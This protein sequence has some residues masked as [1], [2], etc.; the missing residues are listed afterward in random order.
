VID[1]F[2][3]YLGSSIPKTNI[4]F[5]GGVTILHGRLRIGGQ[6]DYRG[7]YLVY[8]NTEKFRCTGAGFN[9]AGINN[10]GD[11]LA[12]Q[13]RAV[14]AAVASPFNP[15][16]GGG[17]LSQAGYLEDGSF[18][19]LR[20]ASLTYYAP[21]SWA[22]AVRAQRLQFTLTGRNLWKRTNYTGLDPEVNGNGTSDLVD[23]F[24][25]APPIRTVALRVTVGF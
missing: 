15:T 1:S 4:T 20:E 18:L 13:A 24:L 21:D 3:R 16:A 6:L 23:D 17:P 7:D 10:P 2:P 11:A 5:N 25:T 22:R 9:C 12:D 8:N 14:A 19:K